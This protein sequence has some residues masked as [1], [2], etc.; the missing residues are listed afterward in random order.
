MKTFY[1]QQ[2]IQRKL[3]KMLKAFN[4]YLNVSGCKIKMQCLKKEVIVA[5]VMLNVN[6]FIHFIFEG[7]LQYV[8]YVSL[9]KFIIS[10]GAMSFQHK[11]FLKPSDV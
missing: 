7:I 11:Y 4:F 1:N 9:V 8:E 10:L 5:T 3:K 6:R 2:I